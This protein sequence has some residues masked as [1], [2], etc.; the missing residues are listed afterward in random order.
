MLLLRAS[1][2]AIYCR[3]AFASMTGF[4]AIRSLFGYFLDNHVSSGVLDRD[5][6]RNTV[7][8]AATGFGMDAWAIAVKYHVLDRTTGIRYWEEAFETTLSANPN[9]N[10]GWL[11]HFIDTAGRPKDG[12]EIST[13]DTA[14][15]YAGALQSAKR[16]AEPRLVQRVQKAIN[17]MDIAW[18]LNNKH[19]VHGLRWQEDK[20]IFL[21]HQWQ[22]FS[23]GWLIYRL[24]HVPYL[25]V[26]VRFD[27]PLFVYYYPMCFDCCDDH[28]L[29]V[30]L[31]RGIAYQKEH[32]GVWG[33]TAC[34]GPN[35]YQSESAEIVSPLAILSRS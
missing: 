4:L 20:A 24:F 27:L 14:I 22:D 23:E 13:I 25:P 6:D 11:Y 33:V 12:S 5:S 8:I 28:A 3:S 9:R 15:F 32:Y 29:P 21:T 34:D 31:R 18:M 19:F 2:V 26:T 30:L 7:S 1:E 17:S 10:R 35:G 16:L